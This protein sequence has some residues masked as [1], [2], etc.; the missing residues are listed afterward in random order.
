MQSE[1]KF[2]FRYVFYIVV[3]NHKNVHFCAKSSCR[4]QSEDPLKN[5]NLPN[6]YKNTEKKSQKNDQNL[7]AVKIRKIADINNQRK[8][9]EIVAFSQYFHQVS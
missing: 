4:I 3:S 9:L 5:L 6:N 1:T 8:K 2:N 7:F